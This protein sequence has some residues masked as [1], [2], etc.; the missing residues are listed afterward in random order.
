MSNNETFTIEERLE[1]TLAKDLIRKNLRD[2][3]EGLPIGYYEHFKTAIL[4]GGAI[5]SVLRKETPNDWDMYL[6]QS[7][8]DNF[9]TKVLAN[10]ENIQSSIMEQPYK[11]MRTQVDGL[12]VTAYATTFVNKLQVITGFNKTHRLEFDFVHCMPYFDMKTQ[13]LH[14]SKQQY[15][16]CKEKKLIKNPRVVKP[17]GEMHT[18]IKRVEKFLDKGWTIH[19]GV[20]E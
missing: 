11:Y 6:E 19:N 17:E 16:A 5:G 3:F 20:F 13:K 10:T 18:S 14:I 7:S 1:I 4:T 12:Y 2:L 8:A 9:M 15:R